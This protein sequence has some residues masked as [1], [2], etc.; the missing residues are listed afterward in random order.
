MVTM[1]TEP[2]SD[3]GVSGGKSSTDLL[4]GLN[5]K[6]KVC[7]KKKLCIPVLL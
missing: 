7:M 2:Q 4:F 5:E 3:D 1:D 6:D